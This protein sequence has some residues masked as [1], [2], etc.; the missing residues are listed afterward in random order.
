MTV[1]EIFVLALAGFGAGVVN[2]IAGGGTFLTFPALVWAGVPPVAANAT[3]AVSVFPGYLGGALGFLSEL[4]TLSRA[5]MIRLTAVT[6]AG[7]LAGSLLLLVS[8]NEVFSYVVPFLLLFATTAFLLGE[9]LQ[10]WA[11]EKAK[12]FKPEGAVGL[13]LVSV[14]G[15]YFNGGLGIVLLALFA[16]WGWRDIHL[17]NGVKNGLSF[18]LSAISVVTFAIAGLVVWPMAVLMMVFAVL[19]GYSGAFVAKAIPASVVRWIV[20]VIGYGMSAVFLARLFVS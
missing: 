14:Y 11:Q 4:K 2:T 9:K 1:L 5:Q 19:G 3:S 17:M 12:W 20:V 8:S 18:A 7:G 16:M 10:A 13:F 6:L 15:G